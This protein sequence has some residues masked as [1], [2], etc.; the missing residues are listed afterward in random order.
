MLQTAASSDILSD[1][2]QAKNVS[3][4]EPI[5]EPTGH[6]EASQEVSS[7]KQAPTEVVQASVSQQSN[8]K[9]PSDVDLTIPHNLD[10]PASQ[11][12]HAVS[13]YGCRI[14]LDICCGIQP[15]LSKA[16]QALKGDLL[17][18]DI[19]LHLADDLLDDNSFEKLL[20]V[21]ASGIVGYAAASPS[22]C[23][24]SRLKLRPGGPPA[25]RTPEFL[26]GRP[27]LTGPQLLKVQESNMMLERCVQCLCLVISS[28]GHAHLEQP[29]SAMSWE[30]PV[31]Q[32]YIIRESCICVAIAACCFGRDWSKTWMLASTF[33]GLEQLAC[34]CPHPA[35]T[36]QP[37]AGAISSTGQFVSRQIDGSI[38]RA[39]R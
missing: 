26:A 31:V 3:L 39:A 4:D 28:G 30:E 2:T 5:L 36:R 15:P 29:S 9:L 8:P 37:I 12:V 18:F 34:S 6:A 38:S 16:V 13:Q 10:V 19:L 27:D 20:R 33:S 24:Y 17:R 32:Q 21:C 11:A 1:S 14:F 35:G 22:C 23:E 7:V 25:L